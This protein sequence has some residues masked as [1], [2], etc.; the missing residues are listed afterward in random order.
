MPDY[1]SPS[2]AK[3]QSSIK[4]LSSEISNLSPSSVVTLFEID[5]TEIMEANNISN[6]GV[7]SDE[8]GFKGDLQKNILRFHNNI[9]IFNSYIKWQG[10][11]YYPAPIQAEGFEVSTRGALPTPEITIATQSE[12]GQNLMGLLR[13]QI[14]KFGDIIGAKVT[15]IKTFAK[16]LDVE[17]FIK[18]DSEGNVKES[19]L[20]NMA[21]E[22]LLEI[23]QGFEPDPYAE[24]PR[25]IYYVERKVSENKAML[26]YQ[27]ASSLD[28][29]GITLPK[30][31]IFADRCMFQ[32]RGPG[33]WYQHAYDERSG[34]TEVLRPIQTLWDGS[35]GVG[36][37]TNVTS[38]FQLVADGITLNIDKG[39]KADPSENVFFSGDVLTFSG[40]ATVTLGDNIQS[41]KNR[42]MYA[43]G[44]TQFFG[45]ISG[46]TI[47]NNE[48]ASVNFSYKTFTSNN[49]NAS[50]T[51]VRASSYANP[52]LSIAESPVF[53]SRTGQVFRL[54]FKFTLT[55]GQM[56]TFQVINSVGANKIS[57][58]K[59]VT[60]T[61][62]DDGTYKVD[63]KI[64]H[65][66]NTASN[67]SKI[68]IFNRADS[69]FSVTNVE[70]AR[71]SDEIPIID[72]AGVTD[73]DLKNKLLPKEAP[74]V[75][76]DNDEKILNIIQDV[77]ASFIDR[78]PWD[79]N[80]TYQK[81]DYVYE[82]KDLIKYYYVAKVD[83]DKGIAPPNSDYWIA[84]QCSKSLKGCRMRWGIKG[85]ANLQECQCV[86]GGP[87]SN[88]K[89]GLPFGGFPA[90]KRVQ[91]T[92]R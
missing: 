36:N 13:Y 19:F 26:K 71:M 77:Q 88:G 10:N 91:Q 23:P 20:T 32:Y 90:A 41:T 25:D 84:D 30:R 59:S 22:N 76:T 7:E 29:E 17:N 4:A 35:A 51:A 8:Y 38:R 33:C 5:V 89:G 82:Q 68:Q 27:L 15:R 81:G 43:A 21:S 65:S 58:S 75:A 56:P 47:G 34:V 18:V 16:F 85:A 52:R 2:K 61:P 1:N 44:S 24:L 48:T 60:P 70:L 92:L 9:N 46:G 14:R 49:N 83:V 72:K 31:V 11:T 69:S 55:S 78:G 74:P 54:K 6:L 40:G 12:E 87:I 67:N 42:N 39:F 53:T 80:K 66:A 45:E 28:L 37:W 57:Y 3:S 79:Q 63:F 86:I 73:P 64:N 50:I 62:L